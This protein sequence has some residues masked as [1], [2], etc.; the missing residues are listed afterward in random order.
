MPVFFSVQP[1]RGKPA[2][3]SAM[4]TPLHQGQICSSRISR[5]CHPPGAWVQPWGWFSVGL[6]LSWSYSDFP[7]A[8]RGSPRQVFEADAQCCP[9]GTCQHSIPTI[10]VAIFKS[11]TTSYFDDFGIFLFFFLFGSSGSYKTCL[12]IYSPLPLVQFH[13]YLNSLFMLFKNKCHLNPPQF[14]HK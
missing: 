7:L 6:W 10:I 12:H 13:A 8:R 5:Q 2:L 14:P 3:E 11:Y 4:V 1:Q 9:L